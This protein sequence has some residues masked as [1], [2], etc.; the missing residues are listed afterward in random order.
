MT[1]EM[2]ENKPKDKLSSLWTSMTVVE[3]SGTEWLSISI[4]VWQLS[5]IL[6]KSSSTEVLF[7]E[8]SRK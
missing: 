8:L 5:S 4:S 1:M 6:G 7:E 2:Y 3:S